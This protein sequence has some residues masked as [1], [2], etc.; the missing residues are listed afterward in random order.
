MQGLGYAAE[1][2]ERPKPARA[3]VP[4]VEEA[5]PE[6]EAEAPESANPLTEEESVLAAETRARWEAEQAAKREAEEKAAAEAEAA[7]SE[8]APEGDA[9][10]AEAAEAQPVEM[11]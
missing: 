8:A 1:R 4:V 9:A 11:E 7:T 6:G 2:S 10:E 3:V 5:A